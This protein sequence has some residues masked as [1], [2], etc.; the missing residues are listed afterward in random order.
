[1][2]NI[3]FSNQCPALPQPNKNSNTNKSNSKNKLDIKKMKSNTIKSLND[4]EAF[5]ND[6]QRFKKYIKLYKILK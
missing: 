1:M 5:L 3:I 2:N 4:V 6:F